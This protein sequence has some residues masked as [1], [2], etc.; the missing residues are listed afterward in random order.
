MGP[1]A[2]D[3]EYEDVVLVGG[4]MPMSQPCSSVQSHCQKLYSIS[5]RDGTNYSLHLALMERGGVEEGD[6]KNSAV[7][8]R[9]PSLRQ[10]SVLWPHLA[11]ANN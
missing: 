3:S 7:V 4:K 10:V 2:N 8:C 5:R 1:K 11:G 9:R 6:V